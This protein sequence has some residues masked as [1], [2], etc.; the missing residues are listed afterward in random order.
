MC[1]RNDF[2]DSVGCCN[3][4]ISKYSCETCE[5]HDRCCSTYE[6]CVSCCM[7]PQYSMNEHLTRAT[8]GLNKPETGTW[9]NVFDLCRGLCRTSSRSTKHENAFILEDR[10]FCFNMQGRP[11]EQPLHTLELPENTSILAGS[12]GLNCVEVC[13]TSGKG[14]AGEHFNLLNSCDVLREYFACEAGCWSANESEAVFPAYIEPGSPK[15]D[16][17]AKCGIAPDPSRTSCED[18]K[19][20]ISRLCIC[21]DA[22]IARFESNNNTGFD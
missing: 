8:I 20:N 12:V 13:Q 21:K 22:K 19:E 14:C 15:A 2:L 1:S 7:K 6:H 17:P 11:K 3:E 4:R 5:V 18:N 16:W 10:H 9:S